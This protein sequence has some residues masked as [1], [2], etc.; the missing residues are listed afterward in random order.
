MKRDLTDRALVCQQSYDELSKELGAM[1]DWQIVIKELNFTESEINSIS[2]KY[3][4]GPSK[5]SHDS[6]F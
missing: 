1:D 3:G 5:V 2:A 6:E 4:D